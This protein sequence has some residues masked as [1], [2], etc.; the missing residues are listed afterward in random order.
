[1]LQ[2]NRDG[3]GSDLPEVHHQEPE[4]YAYALTQDDTPGYQP[5]STKGYYS[6]PPE[7]VPDITRARKG[8]MRWWILALLGLLIAVIA[9]LVGG[10]IGQAIQKNS[11]PSSASPPPVSTPS[12]CPDLNANSSSVTPPPGGAANVVGTIV[13]PDTGCDWPNSKTQRRIDSQTKPFT[14]KYT[15]VCNT[16]WSP[17]LDD[18]ITGVY[19]ISPSDCIEACAKFNQFARASLSTPGRCVGAGFIASWTNRTVAAQQQTGQLFNCY[20][21]RSNE[22]MHENERADVGTEVV[23]LCLEGQCDN[24][25]QA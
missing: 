7:N 18:I 1:M 11:E 3:P 16:G 22:S 8:W 4:S 15:T 2:E 21:M 13:L 25:G 23:A 12:S 6:R 19:T 5:A 10:F 14:T 9:G 24:Y 20:M 17:P